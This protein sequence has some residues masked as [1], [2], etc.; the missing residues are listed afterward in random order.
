[1]LLID[2]Q[3]VAESQADL[4]EKLREMVE[5]GFTVVQSDEYHLLLDLDD[6][7]ALSL[8]EERLPLVQ[9]IMDNS[10]VEESRWHSKSG[11]GWH[12]VLRIEA[13]PA[14]LTAGI[15]LALH[16]ILGSDWKREALGLRRVLMNVA[17]ESVLFQPPG[18]IIAIPSS[19]E[20][21]S[22]PGGL[23]NAH[24]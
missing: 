7:A 24:I 11:V 17:P 18:A 9:Q 13:P 5:A 1:M 12:V 8:Y 22:V 19:E 4:Q 3:Y 6:A 20:V 23:V 16:A 14:P 21:P 15:R 2:P 10:V